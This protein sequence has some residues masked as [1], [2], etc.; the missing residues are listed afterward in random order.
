MVRSL[1]QELARVG[2]HLA[3][4]DGRRDLVVDVAGSQHEREILPCP[5][6]PLND[7]GRVLRVV[8]NDRLGRLPRGS[9]QV[10]PQPREAEEEGA[11]L[12]DVV[13]VLCGPDVARVVDVGNCGAAVIQQR[14]ASGGRH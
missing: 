5:G 10:A 1:V 7:T 4:F 6:P 9:A 8:L 12:S 3:P 14:M 11:E 13:G 2:F